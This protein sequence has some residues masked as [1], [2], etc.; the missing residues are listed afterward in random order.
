MTGAA[1]AA[2][3]PK[4]KLRGLYVATERSVRPG[5]GARRHIDEGIKHLGRHFDL[6][7]LDYSSRDPA[8]LPADA[9]APAPGGPSLL[10][11]LKASPLAGAVRDMRHYARMNAL[12]AEIDRQI[13]DHQVDFVYE[14]SAYLSF[15][16][17]RAAR[18][19]NIPHFYEVNGLSYLDFASYYRSA[20]NPTARRMELGSFRASDHVFFVGGIAELAAIGTD[21]WSRV[22]NGVETEFVAQFAEPRRTPALPLGI[23]FIGHVMQ[24]HKVETLLDAFRAVQRKADV[25]F[26]VIGTFPA[27]LAEALRE[28]VPVTLH[29]VLP[30]DAMA[31]VLADCHVGLVSGDM[32]FGSF[33]KL[34]DYGAARMLAIAPRLDNLRRVFGETELLFAED[35]SGAALGEAINR[36]VE[37]PELVPAFGNRLHDRVARDFTWGAVFD[38]TADAIR[39]TCAAK[40]KAR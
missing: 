19:R 40:G 24:H 12:A 2:E 18:R 5:S 9:P 39:R 14:R 4:R 11:S 36:V 23:C 13:R 15:A 3:V 22:Q 7:V 29:G 35:S 1:D 28:F 21:N 17:L 27:S 30:R 16:A 6:T 38:F 25:E 33:M 8:P 26:H 20:L 32:A 31:S 34:F 10:Q 37:A